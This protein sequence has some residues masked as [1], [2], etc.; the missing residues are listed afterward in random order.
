M[1]TLLYAP[2]ESTQQ[3]HHAL[4][5]IFKF[6]EHGR[7]VVYSK[8]KPNYQDVIHSPAPNLSYHHQQKHQACDLLQYLNPT[9]THILHCECDG[10]PI[11][12][13]LWNTE[14]LKYDYIGAPWGHR[15]C[16]TAPILGTNR[17][18]NGGFS[19]R[20]RKLLERVYSIRHAY[21]LGTYSDVWLCQSAYVRA[22]CSRLLWAPISD[23]IKF[24]F[25]APIPEFPNWS[26]EQS[27]GFHGRNFHPQLANPNP[28][29][30]NIQI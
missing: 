2:V 22:I 25:E 1:T 24:S 26:V 14:W 15:G 20:S 28:T 17:V 10:F 21:P 18:G 30:N 6:P 19:L 13:S 27:F 9:D 4:D 11:N 5:A 29:T 23:A 12:P 16:A 7:V 8:Y 3:I